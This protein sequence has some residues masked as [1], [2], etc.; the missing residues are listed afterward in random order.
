MKKPY[1]NN[2]LIEMFKRHITPG[3]HDSSAKQA[4]N[5]LFFMNESESVRQ[6]K[7]AQMI[8]KLFSLNDDDL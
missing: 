2:F 8:Y 3:L 5:L 6:V 4:S 7:E 1:R